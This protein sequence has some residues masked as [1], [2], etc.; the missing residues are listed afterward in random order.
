MCFTF[1][2]MFPGPALTAEI[3]KIGSARQ[4]AFFLSVA[5]A[6][7]EYNSKNDSFLTFGEFMQIYKDNAS[8]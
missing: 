8:E 3:S 1:W 6:L 5:D 7:E 2:D 4:R